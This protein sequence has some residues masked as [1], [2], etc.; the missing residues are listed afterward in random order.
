MES[1]CSVY[2]DRG[3]RGS[4][5]A[6][7]PC[8]G[9]WCWLLGPHFSP[10]WPLSPVLPSSSHLSRA[11][12]YGV[13]MDRSC[14]GLLRPK[15]SYHP[16]TAVPSCCVLLVKAVTGAVAL[17]RGEGSLHPQVGRD[18]RDAAKGPA[19]WEGFLQPP[20]GRTPPS[21][22]CQ[23]HRCFHSLCTKLK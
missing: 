12:L 14:A 20:L 2:Q 17:E 1:G 10:A 4:R 16:V 8:L 21:P 9:S 22:P 7:L 11:L 23:N 15:S 6:L 5:T 18:H 13:G 3:H 19:E